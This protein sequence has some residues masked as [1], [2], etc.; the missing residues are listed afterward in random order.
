MIMCPKPEHFNNTFRLIDRIDQTVLTV[1]AAGIK[2]GKVAYQLFIGRRILE[3]IF[4]HNG[5]KGFGTFFQ[6]CLRKQA[7]VFHGLL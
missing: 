4:G 3:R 5:K 1:D 2:A 6:S 7:A